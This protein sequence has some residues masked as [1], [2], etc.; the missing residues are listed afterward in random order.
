MQICET[1]TM[2]HKIPFSS[3][4]LPPPLLALKAKKSFQSFNPPASSEVIFPGVFFS[5][6]V[7][8]VHGTPFAHAA[9][10]AEVAPP[11]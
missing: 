6:G 9:E 5:Q 1:F 8:F 10:V 2:H 4:T 3:K 7:F 11:A